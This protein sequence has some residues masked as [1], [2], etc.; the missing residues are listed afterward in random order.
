MGVIMRSRTEQAKHYSKII[1][2]I[3]FVA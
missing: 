2:L 3:L 1:Y